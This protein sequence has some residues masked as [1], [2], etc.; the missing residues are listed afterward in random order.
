[1]TIDEQLSYLRKGTIEIIREA[2]LRAKL[3]PNPSDPRWIQTVW[4]VG[5]RFRPDSR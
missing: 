2:E 5:Y 4:G 3:E 1:M